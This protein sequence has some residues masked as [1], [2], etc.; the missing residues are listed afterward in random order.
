MT[1]VAVQN[2]NHPRQQYSP[3]Q[4]PRSSKPS[5]PSQARPQVLRDPAYVQTQTYDPAGGSS[6]NGARNTMTSRTVAGNDPSKLNGEYMANPNSGSPFSNTN[7][8]YNPSSANDE[9]QAEEPRPTSAPGGRTSSIST[10]NARDS[11]NE[12][13]DR[14][15]TRRRPP[16]LLQRSKSDF[17]PRGDDSDT[18]RHNSDTQD[19]GA[20]HGFEDHYASEE[21]VSQLANVSCSFLFINLPLG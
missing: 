21:Y 8:A 19:W 10:F 11:T 7:G 4:S 14:E 5:P 3:R 9:G 15:L 2:R 18:Q 16:P 12:D 1:A 17:G 20:R 6:S 13:S